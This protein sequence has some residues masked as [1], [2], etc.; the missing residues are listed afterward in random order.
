MEHRRI[1]DKNDS[2][3]AHGYCRLEKWICSDR[4]I[5]Y[6]RPKELT[7]GKNTWGGALFYALMVLCFVTANKMTTAGNVILIQY[8]APVYVALFGFSFLGEKSTKVDWLAIIIILTGLGFFFLDD[9]SFDQL[10]GNI[11]ALV[12][13]FGFAGL[14]LFMRKQ[15]H[16]RPIDS[17]LL[18]NLITFLLCSPFYGQG[19]TFELEPWAMIIFLGM[20][21]LGLAYI[22]YSK[23]IKY[24]SALD[25]VIYPVIEPIFNPMFA[26]LFLGEA[27]SST[28]QI[29]GVLVLLGVIGRGLIQK[30]SSNT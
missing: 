12:S 28:A 16:G 21:Q 9:L 11:V 13:G 3:A 26:F 15:K 19:I 23:A 25:A 5:F 4:N 22:L 14:T 29:G 2:L 8:A 7:F 17:V 10:W 1:H 20:I 24:V 30:S 27:M 6:S 18:G